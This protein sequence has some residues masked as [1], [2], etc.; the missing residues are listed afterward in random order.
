V[1]RGRRPGLPIAPQRRGPGRRAE[2]CP[3]RANAAAA[4][5]HGRLSAARVPAGGGAPT[6]TPF[7]N[8]GTGSVCG[9]PGIAILEDPT[10]S[11]NATVRSVAGHARSA[12]LGGP[13]AGMRAEDTA[14]RGPPPGGRSTQQT[15]LVPSPPAMLWLPVI[16]RAPRLRDLGGAGPCAAASRPGP[17]RSR[18]PPSNLA[19]ASAAVQ[20]LAFLPLIL[21]FAGKSQ[22]P[23]TASE[24]EWGEDGTCMGVC[25]RAR[26]GNGPAAY[27][28]AARRDASA[29]V[30]VK[31][32]A[33][34]APQGA[35]CRVGRVGVPAP[36]RI[37][38]RLVWPLHAALSASGAAQGSG[39]ARGARAP[40]SNVRRAAPETVE[41]A[42]I[43]ATAS[44]PDLTLMTTLPVV[45]G[46]AR[47]Q[48]EVHIARRRRGAQL[49]VRSSGGCDEQQREP[50]HCCG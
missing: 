13:V 30:A 3:S 28:H 25:A 36:E 47:G 9:P 43:A 40:A 17:R 10:R 33:T 15:P 12:G 4:R 5:P 23:S 16:M 41:A 49:Q 35:P 38:A 42:R 27:A 6:C 21:Y 19:S 45:D 20:L 22:V 14:E 46:G 44:V 24:T 29:H 31:S 34:A 50:S 48:Q 18:A 37:A 39:G 8:Q 11:P 32:A 2:R 7:M 1:R 26:S